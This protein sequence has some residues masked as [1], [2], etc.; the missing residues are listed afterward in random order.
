[1]WGENCFPP[2][3]L[4]ARRILS[5]PAT[6]PLPVFVC[7][8]LFV[9]VCIYIYCIWYVHYTDLS[10]HHNKNPLG[11]APPSTDFSTVCH[12]SWFSRLHLHTYSF[13]L[14]SLP[15]LCFLFLCPTFSHVYLFMK[16]NFFHHFKLRN[17][18]L[19]VR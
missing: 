18:R 12:P 9:L 13:L 15:F 2:Y 16:C 4:G 7:A 1:M 14:F 19:S 10:F 6:S 17:E 11:K 8:C 3:L 5:H